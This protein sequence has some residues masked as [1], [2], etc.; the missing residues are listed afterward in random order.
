MNKLLLIVRALVRSFV[1][2]LATMETLLLIVG[3]LVGLS[4]I[5]AGVW[6]CSP[7]GEPGIPVLGIPIIIVG[8]HILTATILRIWMLSKQPK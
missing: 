4:V 8:A 7:L 2:L 6:V 5:L 1:V 3:A